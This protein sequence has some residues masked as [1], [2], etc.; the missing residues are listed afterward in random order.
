[1]G[2][3]SEQGT[4]KARKSWEAAAQILLWPIILKESQPQLPIVSP[5]SGLETVNGNANTPKK[6]RRL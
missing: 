3:L 4:P 5:A 6:G 2:V 1:M